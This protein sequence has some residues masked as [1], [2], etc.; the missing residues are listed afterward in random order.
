MLPLQRS[1]TVEDLCHHSQN[2]ANGCVQ[3]SA[4]GEDWLEGFLA[5]NERTR[6]RDGNFH[7]G[8]FSI[9]AE[10]LGS[11]ACSLSL[12]T[13][14]FVCVGQSINLQHPDI[15]SEGPIRGRASCV[16][17]DEVNQVWKIEIKDRTDQVVCIATLT[18]A[19]L[20]RET[21]A[22]PRNPPT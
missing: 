18:M 4:I 17:G 3:F 16:S 14:R 9:L 22:S 7:P 1:A 15:V 2:T 10:T 5:L 8:A 19:I 13:T 6:D 11:V 21:F 20:D 12:D